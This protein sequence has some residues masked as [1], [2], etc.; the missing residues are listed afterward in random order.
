MFATVIYFVC[1]LSQMVSM[2]YA[3]PYPHTLT[4][5]S[6]Y[7]H[8]IRFFHLV[9]LLFV[10]FS[11]FH[12]RLR[13]VCLCRW[14]RAKS[15]NRYMIFILGILSGH[16]FTSIRWFWYHSLPLWRR[17]WVALRFY[18]W[19]TLQFPDKNKN[20]CGFSHLKLTV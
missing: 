9:W 12:N 5:T 7:K 10:H 19:H 17:P 2:K 18:Q 1:G 6:T 15:R 16:I 20:E 4:H 13:F 14:F 3:S 11:L 8:Q